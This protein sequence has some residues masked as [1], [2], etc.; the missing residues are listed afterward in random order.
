MED[1]PDS[2]L[3]EAQ[4]EFKSPDPAEPKKLQEKPEYRIRSMKNWN[5][6]YTRLQKAREA[7]DSTKSGFW[8]RFKKGY[9]SLADKSGI[10]QQTL[11]LVP[12][13]AIVR[14]RQSC[15]RGYLRSVE[16]A[17]DA[18]EKI[19]AVFNG[20]DLEKTFAQVELFLAIFPGDENIT[21]ACVRLIADILSAIEGTIVYFL[22]HTGSLG[23]SKGKDDFQKELLDSIA[24]I[25]AGT[26]DLID[27]A[28]MSHMAGTRTA[29]F[30]GRP[31]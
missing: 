28:Q 31:R 24:K 23:H 9:R 12:D 20:E 19:T 27:E 3:G 7:F 10:A 1:R 22:S 30:K 17:S 21:K 16:T 4:E 11:K 25:Q 13:L 15:T 18:R 29:M 8:G 26:R 5:A 2:I 6:I 14:T